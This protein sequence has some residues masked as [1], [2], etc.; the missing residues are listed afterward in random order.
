MCYVYHYTTDEGFKGIIESQEIWATS[1]Y[2]LNDYAEFKHGSDAFIE[3]AKAL[4][5]SKKSVDA[6]IQLLSYL[7]DTHPPLFVCSFSAAGDGDDLSQWRAYSRGSGYAIG[8]PIAEL[9]SHA[10]ILRFDLWQ[11]EY[12]TTDASR[13][14]EGLVEIMEQIFEIA[15]GVNGFRLQFPFKDPSKDGMLAMLLKF[16][17]KYKHDAFSA[18]REWRLVYLLK[19]GDRVR[20]RMSDSVSVPYVD[21]SLKN[22][23]LWKQAQIVVSPCLP[24]AAELKRESTSAFL[25]SELRKHNLPTD[26]ARSIRLSKAPYRNMMGG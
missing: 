17:A 6:A 26:C 14:V 9:S 13:F 5:N 11:C 4:L 8:F 1:I 12:G 3:S 2:H 15:G 19:T 24:D 23:E 10:G 25:E 7:S 20:F 22:E 21:F 16:V 18:E